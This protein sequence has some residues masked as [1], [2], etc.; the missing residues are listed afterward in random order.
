MLTGT[1]SHGAHSNASSET[2]WSRIVCLNDEDRSRCCA[3]LR[4]HYLRRVNCDVVL[5]AGEQAFWAH[6]WWVA[7]FSSKLETMLHE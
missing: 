6:R 2:S 3:R 7:A 1:R 5:W 4:R